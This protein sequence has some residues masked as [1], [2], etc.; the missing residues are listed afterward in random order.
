MPQSAKDIQL[1]ELKDTISQLNELIHTQTETMSSLQKTIE[2]LHQQL[3]NKQAELDYCKA[4]LYGASSERFQPPF[5]G[6]MNL[7]ETEPVDDRIPE[8]IESE[9]I[10]VTA[11]KRERKPK[12][13]YE[14]LFANLPSRQVTVDTLSE[15]EKLCPECGTQMIPI[16]TEVIRT[17]I[18]FH[19]ASLERVEYLATTYECPEC[20][21]SLEPQFIKDEGVL[22]LVPH[23]YVSSGLAAHVMYAKFINALP[24]YRQEKDFENQFS[25]KI[26]RGT[27]AHW[28][29]F[30][31]QSYFAPMLDYFHRLLVKRQF[32]AADETPIQVL[33]EKDRRPQSKSYV[34]L[35]RSGDDGL[36]PII[37]Y[38]YHPTRNGDAAAQFFQDASSGTYIMVDGYAGYN[39]LK[40]FRRCSC[41]AH[42]R[43]YFIEAIPK[44]H[45]KD[46]TD[47]AVQ[48]ML[49]CNKLFEYE[50]SYREKRFSY[51]QIYKRRLKDQKP[52]VEAFLAW[53]DKQN[54]SK[55]SRLERAITYVKNQRSYMMTYLEDGR[56]SISNNMSEN[57]IRPVTVGRRNWLF[58]D[59]TDGADASMMVYSLLETARANGLNPQKYLEYLLEARPGKDMSDE[60]LDALAPWNATVQA[61]CVNKSE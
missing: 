5:P 9:V 50:R 31:A 53:V 47:P 29:I 4:K 19:P 39:K 34:W 40:R 38:Q 56:C 45:E 58:C 17:E 55:G 21:D 8:L 1:L 36:P 60:E 48:G 3:S 7:F 52:V 32:V 15:K 28:T 59:T 33:K 13:T 2:D 35:F 46:F 43:R 14:E 22:A 49:Y 11:H 30:C 54:V 20:K 6:Q 12:A 51:K 16:G 42:I 44:G 26:S 37:V 18:L 10:E 27:M 24:F 23:S 57:S 25:V 61:C 41:Y